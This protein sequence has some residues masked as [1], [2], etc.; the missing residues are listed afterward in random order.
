MSSP[1]DLFAKVPA[2]RSDRCEE[3]MFTV[4]KSNLFIDVSKSHK[5]LEGNGPERTKTKT[6][7]Q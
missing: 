3:G 4:L 6:T 7:W 5:F 2:R 1:G